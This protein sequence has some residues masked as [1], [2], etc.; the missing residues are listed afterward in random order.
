[1]RYISHIGPQTSFPVPEGMLDYRGN[2]TMA[3]AIR[4]TQAGGPCL[5]SLRLTAGTPVLTGRRP[6]TAVEAPAWTESGY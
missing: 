4:A 5:S 1:M 2:N 6:V 3:V